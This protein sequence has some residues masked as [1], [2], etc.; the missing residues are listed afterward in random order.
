MNLWIIREK[1]HKQQRTSDFYK[2]V[3]CTTRLV[4]GKIWLFLLNRFFCLLFFH[5]VDNNIVYENY[6]SGGKIIYIKLVQ[7]TLTT[8]IKEMKLLEELESFELVA[9]LIIPVT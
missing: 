7:L 8:G 9:K 5:F 2:L 1:T 6:F 4:L 3:G